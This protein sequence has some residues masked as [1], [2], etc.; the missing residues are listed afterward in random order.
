MIDWLIRFLFLDG[1]LYFACS[2]EIPSQTNSTVGE[3][4]RNF[5]CWRHELHS[6]CFSVSIILQPSPLSLPEPEEPVIQELNY[7]NPHW[8]GCVLYLWWCLDGWMDAC[9]DGRMYVSM[10]V[11]IYVCVDGWIKKEYSLIETRQVEWVY[12]WDGMR[13]MIVTVGVLTS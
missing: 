4:R 10:Y 5:I 13:W 7:W 11:S 8:G 9:M 3:E 1:N 6:L 12:T 2:R